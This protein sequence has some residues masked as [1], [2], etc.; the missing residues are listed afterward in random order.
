M[1]ILGELDGSAPAS[2]D[3]E[4]NHSIALYRELLQP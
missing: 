3:A 1:G 4:T 2:F